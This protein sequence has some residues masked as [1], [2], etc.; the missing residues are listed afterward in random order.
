[1]VAP[2]TAQ[3]LSALL[4]ARGWSAFHIDARGRVLAGHDELDP[5]AISFLHTHLARG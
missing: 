3:L 1:M 2:S 4:E 5:A